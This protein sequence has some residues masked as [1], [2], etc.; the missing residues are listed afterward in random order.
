MES[1][2]RATLITTTTYGTWLP[3]D[4]R[5]YVEGG[6]IL[7]PAP[8]LA[9]YASRQLRREPMLLSELQRHR[10]FESLCAAADEFAYRLSDIVVETTHVHWIVGHDDAMAAMVGRLKT[11][12]RQA[13]QVG[14]VWTNGYCG[15]RLETLAELQ[16][17]RE[18]LAS[19]A[20]VK[21]I[22]GKPRFAN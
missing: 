4:A 8:R 15:R 22:A 5:G 3:G 6:R 1:F 18:Y 7:P 19:H 14:R 10:V 21:M 9:A 11:R 13:L 2:V 16:T 20:G 12:T 17:A